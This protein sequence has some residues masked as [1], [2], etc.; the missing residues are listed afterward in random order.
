MKGQSPADS[1]AEVMK[2]I[3]AAPMTRMDIADQAGVTLDTATRWIKRLEAHGMLARHGRKTGK[4]CRP[5][6]MFAVTKQ[7]GGPA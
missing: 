6:Q 4:A 1:F 7:W 5:A 2:A 3:K